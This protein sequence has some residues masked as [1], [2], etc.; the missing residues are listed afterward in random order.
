MKI[1]DIIKKHDIE[2]QKLLPSYMPSPDLS[3]LI[4]GSLLKDK[5]DK[6]YN[7]S[8]YIIDPRN[9]SVDIMKT[10]LADL[11]QKM[12]NLPVPP[13]SS[14]TSFPTIDTA[15]EMLKSQI[16]MKKQDITDLTN[17]LQDPNFT[18]CKPNLSVKDADAIYV[19]Y[20]LNEIHNI[21]ML[22]ESAIQKIQEAKTSNILNSWNN[23]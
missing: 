21:V 19:G 5:K 15:R 6:L 20:Q 11:Q 7:L 23:M 12:E 9:C 4:N 18:K 16:G 8:H 22:H 14:N 17:S 1:L 2:I 13:P 10:D 3:G